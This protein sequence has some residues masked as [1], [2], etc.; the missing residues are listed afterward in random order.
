MPENLVDTKRKSGWGAWH[1]TRD[2]GI[3]SPARYQLRHAPAAREFI[4][5]FGTFVKGLKSG[6]GERDC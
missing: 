2:L 4:A 5:H 6:L 1:R 3:Q